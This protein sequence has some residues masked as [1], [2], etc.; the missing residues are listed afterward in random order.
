MSEPAVEPPQRDGPGPR[1]RRAREARG[2]S[3]QQAAEQLNLDATVVTAIENDDLAVVR[4]GWDIV[5]RNQGKISSLVM[6]M[7]SFSKEREPD[8]VPTDLVA[9]VADIVE[10]VQQRAA[11]AGIAIRWQ[12]PGDL[13]R[14]V[15]DP[16]GISRAILNVVTNALDAVENRPDPWVE[17][18]IELD[19]PAG[20]ARV[21]IADNGEGMSPEAEILLFS[22]SRAQLTRTVIAPALAT[23]GVVIADRFV[24]STTVYQGMARG[25]PA[26]AVAAINR[27]AT[28]GIMPDLTVLLDIDVAGSRD[29][30]ASRGLD[31]DRF[32][33]EDDAFF[34]RVRQGYL[35]LAAS[36]PDRFLVLDA[37]ETPGEIHRKIMERITTR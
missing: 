36:A 5:G 7:L 20:R 2:L 28:C 21:I 30:M 9:L 37:R 32:E 27:F 11:D 19:Q 29:R 15:F 6:D 34:E 33:R 23:G 13:P 25:L 1:L 8:P 31:S 3:V 4:K 12:P 10:T 17:I 14:L 26:E 16:E 18:R 35:S 24:D 22:A